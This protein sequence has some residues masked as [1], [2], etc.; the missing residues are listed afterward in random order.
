MELT[1]VPQGVRRSATS[2]RASPAARR[3]AWRS[4]SSRC[5][6]RRSRSSTRPTPAWT[7]TRS[8]SSP[9]ASTPSPRTPTWAS[10]IITHYQRILHLVQPD[11]RVDHVRRPDRQGG[12]PRARR[13]SSSREGYGGIKRARSRRRRLTAMA[14]TA[15]PATSAPQFPTL[16][17]EGVAY[18]DSA[19]T[20]Q[21]PAAVLAAM[22]DY[23]R[24]HRASVHRGVYPLAV[25]ATDLLRGRARARRGRSSAGRR[26]T[27]SSRRN[28]TEAINLV[29]HGWGRRNVG[30]GD[31]D[32]RH[33]RWSTTPTSC[34]GGC[35]R[36]ETGAELVEVAR[37][38]TRRSSTS[39]RSTRCCARAKVLA[40]THV[41]NVRR[42]DQPG[43]RHRRAAPARRASSRSSTARRPCRRSPSTSARSTPTSTPGP[44]TRPTARPGVGILHGRRDAAR[45]RCRRSSAAA[46]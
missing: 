42:H 39:T 26:A 11:A 30:A 28:A 32:P 38:T 34:R 41:S 31:R 1:N 8:T 35:S 37:S 36:R 6:S 23:Y 19:A 17:R 4:C 18:L 20:S 45:R 33:A 12:R 46:T 3:S 43:R 16:Q 25:E 44:A 7:S 29:A 21:T 9:T 27:R 2:T 22:D 14:A 10:L 24:H 15:A 13:R 5:S 40:F